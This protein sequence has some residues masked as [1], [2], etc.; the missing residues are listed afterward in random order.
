M[1]VTES[2]R[3]AVK[4]L[5]SQR[6]RAVLTLF[7]VGWGTAALIFLVSWGNGVG[8]MLERGMTKQ[9][10]NLAVVWA[11]RISEEY[12]AAVDRRYLWYT[13]QDVK[14]LRGRARLAAQEKH[15]VRVAQSG[16]ELLQQGFVPFQADEEG[17]VSQ[18]V[19]AGDNWILLFY[20]L[21]RVKL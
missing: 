20:F 14:A 3:Q 6:R 18:I 1:V 13:P 21:T 5:A 12:T 7:G 10:K 8:A 11:G 4:T 17:G 2:I 19:A 9:G 16:V 15:P